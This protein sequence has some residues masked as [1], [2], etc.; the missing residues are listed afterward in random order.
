MR[1]FDDNGMM[2]FPTPVMRELRECSK[3]LVVK[4]CYCPRGH[5]LINDK[6]VFGD[7]EGIL[8]RMR[9]GHS[10][11]L[12][13]LSPVYGDK[14]RITLGLRPERGDILTLLCPD[15]GVPLPVYDECMCGGDILALFTRPVPDFGNC[16]GICNRL[17]CHH[18]EI[19]NGDEL[20]SYANIE[21]LTR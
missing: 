21:H 10:E 7:F 20:L 8:L 5:N 13:A 9:K 2:V 15:C 6:V 19:R 3:A 11:G 18:A 14:S 16:V 4:A 12:L 17:G 1:I